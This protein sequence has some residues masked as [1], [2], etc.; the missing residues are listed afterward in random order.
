M[1]PFNLILI[2]ALS[3]IPLTA[4]ASPLHTYKAKAPAPL[5]EYQCDPFTG[6]CTPVVR[7]TPLR[8]FVATR[9]VQTVQAPAPAV[10]L[11]PVQL[12]PVQTA[13]TYGSTGT[14]AYG[15]NG[16]TYA[17]QPVVAY[18]FSGPTYGSY[19]TR[20]R[21]TWRGVRQRSWFRYR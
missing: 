1:R 20:T 5:Q 13:V 11:A 8:T 21:R 17:A 6:I 2:I 4:A 14:V 7:R 9:P 12:A 10:Q 18:S 15:C 16:S 19:G 3:V